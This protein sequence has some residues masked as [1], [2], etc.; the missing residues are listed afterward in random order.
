MAQ[1]VPLLVV[2]AVG[3][4]RLRQPGAAQDEGALLVYAD[5]VAHGAV[6]HR[7]FLTFYGP[8]MPWVLGGLFLI[9]GPSI[10]VERL[11][12]L[13]IA[14]A[15]VLLITR[16]ARRWGP[17]RAAVAGAMS[18]LALVQLPPYSSPWL[19]AVAL[20]LASLA[21]TTTV[22]AWTQ[23]PWRFAVAGLLAA[24][25][26]S[27]RIDLA[28]AVALA[29]LPL[30]WRRERVLPW[31]AGGVVLGLLPLGVHVLVATP[32][33]VFQNVFIDAVLRQSPARHL[34]LPPIDP[35]TALELIGV[36]LAVAV[37][38]AAS[39]AAHRR[40]PGTPR[41]RLLLA[42]TAVSIGLLPEMFQ[43][44]DSVHVFY[45]AC[46]C[47]AI[48][49]ISLSVII[50]ARGSRAV[51]IVAP[52]TYAACIAVILVAATPQGAPVASSGREFPVS[53]G[54]YA[55]THTVLADVGR[56][57]HPG[58]RLFVG[59]L[60]M[61]RTNYTASYLYFLLPNLVPATYFLEMEPL[62]ANR[63]DSRLAADVASAD[64]LVLTTEWDGWN[65]PNTSALFGSGAPNEV[66][67]RSFCLRASDGVYR[68]YSRCGS[69]ARP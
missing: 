16:I 50:H 53:Q 54:E 51:R 24:L 55:N 28:P 40:T 19:A 31:Y 8:G 45:A 14:A 59:P 18:A 41:T 32:A 15:A 48:L 52:A 23:P 2:I 33:A 61:R 6:A 46:V 20:I 34:P 47:V 25:A 36:T 44:A 22:G 27:F 35:T 64:I 62:I 37:N 43:R 68:V 5:R 29:A 69:V 30:L 67:E 10:V 57:G 66:V 1:A 58:E 7:D 49:P 26:L 63:S 13:F 38:V 4:L 3:L 17:S 42:L 12:S 21:V 39:V 11:L 56:I 60:D 9:A 65:E